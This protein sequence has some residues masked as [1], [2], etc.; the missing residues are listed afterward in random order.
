MQALPAPAAIAYPQIDPVIVRIGPVGVHWYGLAYV[1]GFLVA[2]LV[3]RALNRRWKVGLTDDDVLTAVLYAIVGVLVGGRLG[4][5]LFYGGTTYV[6]DPSRILL[7]WQGGMSWHGSF[8]GILLAGVLLK[9]RFKIPFLRLADMAAVGAPAGFFFGRL[10]NFVNAELWGRATDLPW[11]MVFPGTDGLPRHPSQ[12]YEATLEGFVMFVVLMLLALR[13]RADGFFFGMFA[14]MYGA[15]RFGIEFVREP[16]AQ[17]GFILG[18]FTMGQALSAPLVLVGAYF[19]FRAVKQDREQKAA[20]R[21]INEAARKAKG[22][23]A[24]EPGS[25]E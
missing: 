20:E 12:L 5:V 19:V 17:L 18:P 23:S 4:Y 24:V 7:V 16:D 6:E 3:F 21:R 2:G 13:K 14:L 15:F 8:V 9:R 11:G 25:E 1:A 10:A 22:A